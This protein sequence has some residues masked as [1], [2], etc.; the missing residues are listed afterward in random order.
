PEPQLLLD[1]LL[2]RVFFPFNQTVD[3]LF[4]KLRLV[5]KKTIINSESPTPALFE[6]VR[7]ERCQNTLS[8]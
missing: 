7:L 6:L 4:S 1:V 8:N 3:L 2:K 5:V